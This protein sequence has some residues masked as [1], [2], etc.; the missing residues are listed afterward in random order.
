MSSIKLR[1][2]STNTR[3]KVSHRLDASSVLSNV[4]SSLNSISS[5]SLSKSREKMPSKLHHLTPSSRESNE[6]S[7][8]QSL[9]EDSVSSLKSALSQEWEK[10]GVP[11]DLQKVF[12]DKVWTLPRHKATAI[13]S[14]ELEDLK[15]NRSA[16]MSALR[17]VISREE[18][19]NS[20]YEMEKFLKQVPNW[21]KLKDVHLECAELLHA[22]RILTI[23]AVETIEKWR[24]VIRSSA[25]IN[26]E[27]SS[28]HIP[29]TYNEVNYIVKM[30]NDLDFLVNSEFS[31][32]FLF[33]KT[34]PLL[35]KPSV[36]SVKIKDRKIDSNYFI[37][38]GQVVVSLPSSLRHKVDFAMEIMA[39]EI[40]MENR[41]EPKQIEEISE[42]IYEE[43]CEEEV[44]NDAE[45]YFG[46]NRS[47]VLGPLSEMLANSML[48]EFFNE[49][50]REVKQEKN[51][52]NDEKIGK[53]LMEDMVNKEIDNNLKQIA[54][55][56][57]KNWEKE[58]K[59]SL[60]RQQRIKEE[61]ENLARAIYNDLFND[62]LTS[63]TTDSVELAISDSKA[64]LSKQRQAKILKENNQ[65]AEEIRNS[66]IDQ[67]I[68]VTLNS[69]SNDIQIQKNLKN[70]SETLYAQLIT[71]LL[72][73]VASETYSQSKSQ[74]EAK[75]QKKNEDLSEKI[76]YDLLDSLMPELKIIAQETFEYEIQLYSDRSELLEN[77][78][79]GFLSQES[80]GD[81]SDVFFKKIN[82]PDSVFPKIVEEYFP[83]IP[84]EELCVTADQEYL[85]EETSKFQAHWYWG[86][87]GNVIA[88]LLVFS[89]D[90]DRNDVRV[91][92]VHHLTCL[93]WKSYG[94]F[95]EQALRFI[96]ESDHC[97]EI[98]VNLYVP[99]G[100]E[101]PGHI[102]K[103]FNS[104]QFRWKTNHFNEDE[105][106]SIIVMGKLRP[107][108]KLPTV[109]PK[110]AN[111]LPKSRK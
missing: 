39:I 29:F 68:Q 72:T 4:N 56:E 77:V 85:E 71:E 38:H 65:I 9:N 31:K 23:N 93:N 89:V 3:L 105:D 92:N 45:F 111:L 74:I 73:E 106:L 78:G 26:N 42:V 15:K 62:I 104:L 79:F 100:P 61:N 21:E 12:N 103:I 91:I 53:S 40:K 58:K 51:T 33:D 6:T 54:T 70:S 43:L 19:L 44:K 24:D 69:I 20:I 34:D 2:I 80:W 107:Q 98:R 46:N 60:T 7:I 47:Q 22:H 18:S 64:V 97:Q 66:Y 67:E 36:P 99:G 84:E 109:S 49:L 88:G 14:R 63:M 76:F 1:S 95:I 16:M 25:L 57:L 75:R 27:T 52:E 13:A 96:W 50:V 41:L 10:R 48:D 17:A 8:S 11:K 110:K 83:K 108:I 37:Q 87:K 30:R 82:A 59:D 101:I 55:L 94:V 90:F 35:I 86:A 5:N 102:K 81:F 28:I 32:V